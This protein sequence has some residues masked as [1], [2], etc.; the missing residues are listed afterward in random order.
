M[1]IL[2]SDL[3]QRWLIALPPETKKRVRAAVRGLEKGRGDI[4]ALRGELDGF[5]VCGLTD[6]GLLFATSRAN[7]PAGIR[8]QPRRG[9]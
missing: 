9:L 1:K 3:V 4:K 5:A 2:A 8:R 7:H 6:C